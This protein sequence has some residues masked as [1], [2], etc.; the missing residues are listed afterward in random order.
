MSAAAG[1]PSSG[2]PPL[3]WGAGFRASGRTP[4]GGS[5]LMV[6]EAPAAAGRAG[7]HRA[8]LPGELVHGVV[9]ARPG[10]AHVHPGDRAMQPNGEEGRRDL[11]LRPSS[12]LL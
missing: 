8:E 9:E 12:A 7:D 2:G 4:D 10:I 6:P 11:E 5:G 1:V 3:R